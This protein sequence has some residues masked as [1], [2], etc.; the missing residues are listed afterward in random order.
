M[1][2][3]NGGTLKDRKIA[4]ALRLVLKRR[5]ARSRCWGSYV[6]KLIA[7]IGLDSW[8]PKIVRSSQTVASVSLRPYCDRNTQQAEAITP[9]DPSP[10]SVS[11]W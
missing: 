10:A 9:S 1:L 3:Q 11:A 5:S 8:V 7:V 2:A 6:S 4:L